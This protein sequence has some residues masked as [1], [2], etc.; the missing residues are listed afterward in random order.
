MTQV[1]RHLMTE[2]RPTL[3]RPAPA[4]LTE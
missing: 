1:A 4:A 3:L 2:P